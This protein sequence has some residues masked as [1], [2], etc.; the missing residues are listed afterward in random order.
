MKSYSDDIPNA[1]ELKRNTAITE[2][3]NDLLKDNL[4][5][6]IE[7]EESMDTRM[8]ILSRENTRN[9]ILLIVAVVAIGA[10]LALQIV[11]HNKG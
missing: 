6:I 11:G 1:E 5:K 2:A 9:T 10:S 7:H 3:T 4:V 8:K